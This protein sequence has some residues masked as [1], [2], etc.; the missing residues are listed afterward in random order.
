MIS[1]LFFSHIQCLQYKTLFYTIFMLMRKRYV[2]K[3]KHVENFH[4]Y[5]VEYIM[6][7]FIFPS[8]VYA[9]N[10]Q[11]LFS[12]MQLS[13]WLTTALI[14]HSH[15]GQ[16]LFSLTFQVKSVRINSLKFSLTKQRK[17]EENELRKAPILMNIFSFFL[18]FRFHSS[19]IFKASVQG[20]QTT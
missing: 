13:F 8:K 2:K 12:S 4:F 5:P 18:V 6:R 17:A 1:Y 20:S 19:I 16:N 10:F 11:S 7:K 15:S 14:N 3:G 9:L